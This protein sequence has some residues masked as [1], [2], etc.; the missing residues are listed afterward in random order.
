MDNISKSIEDDPRFE[1]MKKKGEKISK[2]V[3]EQRAKAIAKKKKKE[4]NTGIVKKVSETNI[5][6]GNDNKTN[7]KKIDDNFKKKEENYDIPDFEPANYKQEVALK[8]CEEFKDRGNLKIYLYC[9]NRR[10]P[11]KAL[12]VLAIIRDTPDKDI[13]ANKRAMFAY[14][15]LRKKEV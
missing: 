2:K 10:G 13:H 12:R 5:G 7:K 6:T 14:Y 1:E 3:R 8:I 15:M 4:L 11:D 9:V